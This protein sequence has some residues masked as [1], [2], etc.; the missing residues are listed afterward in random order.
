[1]ASRLLITQS[2]LS[3]WGYMFSCWEGQE[4]KALEEFLQTLRRERRTPN[5]AMQNGIDFE[6]EVYKVAAGLPRKEHKSWE[7]GIKSVATVLRGAPTQ[8]K[9]SR[10]I[11]VGGQKFLVY[12]ILD[13]LK[14]GIIYDVKFTNKSLTTSSPSYTVGKYLDSVQHP[15]Y[16]ELVPEATEF[17]YLVSDGKDMCREVYRRGNTRPFAEIIADFMDSL[18]GMGLMELYES[19]WTALP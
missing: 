19:K 16:F 10:E 8:V 15:A 13:A 9:L 12:G 11:E 18:K 7:Q 4:D 6:R 14:A 17:H 5:E 3:S 2:L 1:M